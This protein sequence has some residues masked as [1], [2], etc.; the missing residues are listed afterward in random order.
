M[1]E[2]LENAARGVA[3]DGLDRRQ[4]SSVPAVRVLAIPLEA[5]GSSQG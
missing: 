3:L 2:K 1:L 5:I 4:D